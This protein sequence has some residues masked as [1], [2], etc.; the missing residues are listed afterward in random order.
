MTRKSVI[1]ASTTLCLGVQAFTFQPVGRTPI[2]SLQP[3]AKANTI[4]HSPPPVVLSG[5]S[6]RLYNDSNDDASD[7]EI[8]RL[9]SM[10]A[11][12]R[13]EASALEA[14]KANAL[15]K[16]AEKAFQEFDTNQ[17]GEI[18]VAELKAGLE[19]VLKT[20]L[21]NSRVQGLMAAFD[22]SGDGT[23]QLDE[24]VG[25]DKFR[26]K[27]EALARE[28]KELAK[29]AE[30]DAKLEQ[31][32]AALAEARLNFLNEKDPTNSDKVLS[33]LPYL[34]PLMDGL[35]YGQFIFQNNENNPLVIASV[36]LYTIYRSIPFSGFAAF[37]ALNFLSNNPKL[38][39][40]VR[41]NMQQAIF[42]DI[43]LFF[44]GLVSGLYTVI[45]KA[46]GTEIPP[47]YP[48]VFSTVIFTTLLISLSYCTVSS[49]LGVAPD[50]LPIVSQ[51]VSNRMP[52]IDMFDETGRFIPRMPGPE[53]DDK[54][55][56]EK[57]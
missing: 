54:E 57:K 5:T 44:P 50:K 24:F 34:F 26:N 23:L 25:V 52:T 51:A 46:I 11:S 35:Q 7:N 53:E 28:E 17:D 41:F 56:E 36:I 16:A 6:S 21:S 32:A 38:N 2:F 30:L 18:S 39:R 29:Q 45:L 22:A 47:G 55:D 9:R 14:E 12:L 31:E 48:E 40:L 13:A 33:V 27:L 37:F 43:A 20:E 42:V 10:A 3:N 4:L 1:L 49:L 15:A 8:D 19:K